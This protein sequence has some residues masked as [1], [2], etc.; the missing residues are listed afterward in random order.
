MRADQPSARPLR[1]WSLDSLRFAME[2]RLRFRN[3]ESR[4]GVKSFAVAKRKKAREHKC[5]VEP[6]QRTHTQ[7][8]QRNQGRGKAPGVAKS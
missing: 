7:D 4:V 2:F 6:E 1:P 8:G 5:M 3:I